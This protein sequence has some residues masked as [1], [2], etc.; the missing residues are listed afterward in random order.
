MIFS[1][2]YGVYYSTVAEILRAAVA[3]PVTGEE[4]RHI[5]ETHAFSES[6]LTIEPALRE[7]RWQLLRGD[8]STPCKHPPTI[9]LTSLERRWLKAISL[10][11]RI[12]LFDWAPGGLEEVQ[13]LFTPEDYCLSDRY[14][15]GD[16]YEDPGYIRNFRLI[17][18]AIKARRPLRLLIKT[19]KGRT[20]RF[21]VMP[22]ELEYSEK[23]DKFR[24][25]TGGNP[26][27]TVVNLGRILECSPVWGPFEDCSSVA[28][29]A[30]RTVT[31]ELTD[32]RNALERVMLHFSHFEKQAERLDGNR[33]RLRITYQA[34]DETE[35]VIRILS[36]GP[37]LRVTGPE[38][39]MG[40]IRDRLR[41]QKS[42][43]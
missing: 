37:H 32:R 20:A 8:G 17:L 40:L 12:R 5:V 27:A 6:V 15:D 22:L 26:H 13:P 11:P 1:E 25:L 10:D 16:P 28:V 43:L 2:L 21:R 4:L 42:L 35:L 18:E 38:T 3:R 36:F 39:F 23:D 34:D 29:D 19:R 24:L 31:L 41:R 30:A 14:S 7:G 33:Y 9:P